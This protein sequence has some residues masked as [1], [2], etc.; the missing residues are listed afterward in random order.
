MR[1]TRNPKLESPDRLEH[2]PLKA[3]RSL[4]G[5]IEDAAAADRKDLSSQASVPLKHI[6]LRNSGLTRN[7]KLEAPDRLEHWPLKASRSLG[8]IILKTEMAEGESA[9][10][11]GPTRLP[12]S[13]VASSYR[14]NRCEPGSLVEP[15]TT[16]SSSLSIPVSR[17]T[18]D[19]AAADRKA[20]CDEATLPLEK[21]ECRNP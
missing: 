19:A 1:L 12:A 3:S 15:S 4:G 6:E 5:I 11:I 21:F 8:G 13:R 2:W 10:V 16:P 14:C 18:K 20:V 7:P 9:A 17:I